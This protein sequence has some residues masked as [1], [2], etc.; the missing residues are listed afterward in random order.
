MRDFPHRNYE[1]IAL[2]SGNEFD[3]LH[4]K[5]RISSVNMTKSTVSFGFGHID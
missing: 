5:L 1:S 2:F 3:A 4:K